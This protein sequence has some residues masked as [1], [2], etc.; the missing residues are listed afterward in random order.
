MTDLPVIVVSSGEPAGIGPDICIAL[1]ER[2][3]AARLAVLG[4]PRLLAERGH[5]LG[6]DL[7]LRE[8][9]DAA[10]VGPHR[11][12]SLQVLPVAL[13]SP[14]HAGEPD[15]RNAPYVLDLL[16]RGTELCM[17]GAAQALVTAP[18]QK[19]VISEAGFKFSGHTEFLAELTG[20]PRPVMLLAS[21][22]LRVLLATTHLPLRAVPDAIT[23]AGLEELIRVA[24]ADLERRFALDR[25]RLLVLG[26]NPHA[27]ESGTL[28][29]EE[30]TV[31]EPVVR[32]LAAAGIRIEGPVS[33]D[34]A[35]TPES[36]ER[37]DAV[38]AM[39][40]DQGLP[41][42]KALSFGE[43][44]NVTLGLPIVRTSV[45]HGT[46]LALAGTG[47]ARPESLFAAVDLAL[48]LA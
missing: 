14:V 29:T 48:E 31:I 9:A 36:L 10:A 32:R 28:G 5:A 2:P 13:R 45:D 40:H 18:V 19:S 8:C 15:R 24:H 43:I 34:T 20:A 37:C 11:L 7:R 30:Q 27:G 1:A 41:A 35:F 46:A 44:V 33:A 39:Y 42:L 47:R 16:R 4:D 22:R 38:V 6:R 12:G 17:R 23:P 25:P 3:I 26:L 21:R